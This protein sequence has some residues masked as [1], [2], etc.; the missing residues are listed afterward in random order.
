VNILDVIHSRD[1]EE[2]NA[3]EI[4][5]RLINYMGFHTKGDFKRKI[6]DEVIQAYDV[7]M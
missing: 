6:K 3:F 5:K 7:T 2:Y 4:M 1:V